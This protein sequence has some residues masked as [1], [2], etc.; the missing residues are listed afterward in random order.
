MH[1]EHGDTMAVYTGLDF[2]VQNSTDLRSDDSIGKTLDLQ[3]QV[4]GLGP[5]N[6]LTEATPGGVCF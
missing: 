2:A 4:P 1:K 6:R 3:A 5:Q